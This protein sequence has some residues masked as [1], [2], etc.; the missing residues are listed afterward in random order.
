MKNNIIENKKTIVEARTFADEEGRKVM[1][2]IPINPITYQIDSIVDIAFNG[3]IMVGTNHGPMAFS[4]EF[5]AH[6][7][8]EECFENFEQVAEKEF[9][10]QLEKQKD[11]NRIVT[12]DQLRS[13]SG[14]DI[15][16]A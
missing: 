2:F 15:L 6:Y 7:T 10:A 8:L 1:A 9:E 12:P 5:P 16:T 4:F 11:K 13:K 14:G 3:E